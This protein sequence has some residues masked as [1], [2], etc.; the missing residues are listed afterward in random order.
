MST[1]SQEETVTSTTSSTTSNHTTRKADGDVE[2]GCIRLRGQDSEISDGVWTEKATQ[3]R[4]KALSTEYY[5]SKMLFVLSPLPSRKPPWKIMHHPTV[6]E[7]TAAL[8]VAEPVKHAQLALMYSI[9]A[10]S[11]FH[12]DWCTAKGTQTGNIVDT[13]SNIRTYW[14][15]VGEQ[16]ERIAKAQLQLSL[17]AEFKGAA[18]AKYKHILM[19][20]LC[21]VTICVLKGEMQ[22]ARRFLLDA[23]QVIRLRGL[24]PNPSRKIRLLHNIFLYNRI[25]EESTFVRTEAG[26]FEPGVHP[27]L[28]VTALARESES[29]QISDPSVGFHSMTSFASHSMHGSI[30][31]HLISAMHQ[32]LLIFFYKRIRNLHPYALQPFVKGTI[33]ELV[34]FQRAKKDSGIM[35][36][37]P[38]WPGFIAGR[39]AMDEQDRRRLRE[40]FKQ[41]GSGW[42]SFDVVR[43]MLEQFW[44]SGNLETG[45]SGADNRTWEHFSRQH[46]IAIIAT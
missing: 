34:A 6:L 26:R 12:L 9:L 39:E 11:C 13:G 41:S 23:E 15:S 36:P 21:M 46:H 38:C 16:F 3:M 43:D 33:S 17:E 18:K 31:R 27:S 40:W 29:Q 14:W 19:T 4:R 22:N 2:S 20:L 35:T 45:T 25:I 7:T 24:K 37:V 10:I 42:R 32:A 8:L 1:G 30:M 5:G 44:E 28:L